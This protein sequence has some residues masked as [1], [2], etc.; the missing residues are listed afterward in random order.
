[1]EKTDFIKIIESRSSHRKFLDEKIDTGDIKQ[2]IKAAGSAPSGHNLQPWNF[3]AI[4]NKELIEKIANE[5]INNVRKL[6]PS[7]PEETV[8]KFKKY[9]F[10]IDHF[11]TAPLI[12]VVLGKR[13]PYFSSKLEDKY[14]VKLDTTELFNMELL[15]IGAAIENLILSAISLGYGSC[16]LTEPVYYAQKKI[17]DLLDIKDEYHVVSILSIGKPTKERSPQPKK[18]LEEIFTLIE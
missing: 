18:D 9:E 13:I 15:G 7:L 14:N 6:H 8:E 5:V 4:K 16:W 12:I 10:F 1:M 17:E 3:I 2:M 11:K